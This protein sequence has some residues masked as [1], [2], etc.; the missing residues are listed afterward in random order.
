MIELKPKEK[1]ELKMVKT[2]LED[3]LPLSIFSE[4]PSFPLLGFLLGML[5]IRGN[6]YEEAFS[7]FK[8]SFKTLSLCGETKKKKNDN[9]CI[10]I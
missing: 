10:L 8:N 2:L 5:F 1:D 7:L 9:G 4:T 6:K 3:L